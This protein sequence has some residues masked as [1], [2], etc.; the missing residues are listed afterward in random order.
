MKLVMKRSKQKRVFTCGISPIKKFIIFVSIMASLV[1]YLDLRNRYIY[2]WQEEGEGDDEVAEDDTSEAAIDLFA[3]LQSPDVPLVANRYKIQEVLGTG[4]VSHAYSGVDVKTQEEVVLKFTYINLTESSSPFPL[5]GI[6]ESVLRLR[7]L[8]R[9]YETY[10]SFRNT[11][12]LQSY[13]YGDFIDY[14][15]LVTQKGGESVLQHQ[16]NNRKWSKR[17]IYE[18]ARNVI[19]DLEQLHNKNFI[20]NDM[21]TGNIAFKEANQ[22]LYQV[23]LIDFNGA[24]RYRD[25]NT[26]EHY[27]QKRNYFRVPIHRFSPPCYYKKLTCSRRDDLISLGY[28]LV[29]LSSEHANCAPIYTFS[30]P[31]NMSN[32][33]LSPTL[34]WTKISLKQNLIDFMI[35]ISCDILQSPDSYHEKLPENFRKYFEH[36]QSLQFDAKPNYSYLLSLFPQ[37]D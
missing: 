21:H 33:L 30:C 8:K 28:M 11:R 2:Q 19:L 20:H 6:P 7:A 27:P 24:K 9:E 5:K 17:D 12:L 29:M 13:Y 36:M 35:N 32:E 15:V 1:I 3:A 10:R 31:E 14:K 16:K 18:L 23:N 34:P 37:K 4:F 22:T 25:I 26:F